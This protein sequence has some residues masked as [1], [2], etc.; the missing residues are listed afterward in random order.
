MMKDKITN[1]SIILSGIIYTIIISVSV[2]YLNH[3]AYYGR[4]DIET[5]NTSQIEI[6]GFSPL[7][8]EL[9]LNRKGGE[10]SY[11]YNRF[12]K[13]LIIKADNVEDLKGT[14]IYL[15]NYQINYPLDYTSL[16]KDESEKYY[17]E[18][19]FDSY[20]YP[21]NMKLIDI[22][23]YFLNEFKLLIIIVLISWLAFLFS[24]IIIRKRKR[25]LKQ[26]QNSIKQITT[27]S[28]SPI[29]N[30]TVCLISLLLIFLLLL[31]DKNN[32]DIA[33]DNK[34]YINHKWDQFDYHTIAAN[35]TLGYG[36]YI[37]GE[38]SNTIDYKMTETNSERVDSEILYRSG[39]KTYRPP[40]YSLFAGV[41][42]SIFG[43]NPIVIKVF[44]IILLIIVVY[45]LPNLGML[46][47]KKSGYWAGIIAGPLFIA[48][49][50][51]YT[52]LV[53]PETF[54]LTIN[55]FFVFL[56]LFLRKKKTQYLYIFSGLLLGLSILIKPSLAL[57][58]P[59][60]LI[61]V[62][63]IS[64]KNKLRI[65]DFY[66][67]SLFTFSFL[68]M[69]LPYN[70][71]T[72]HI[73]QKLSLE[74]SAYLSSLKEKGIKNTNIS[75]FKHIQFYTYRIP[76][77]EDKDLDYF[78]KTV[79][80]EIDSLLYIPQK[81]Y[82]TSNNLNTPVAFLTN[83]K[84]ITIYDDWFL[85]QPNIPLIYLLGFHNEY[86]SG[87]LARY[88]DWIYNP[89]SYYNTNKLDPS[90][91][92][93]WMNFYIN[94]PKYFIKNFFYK[95]KYAHKDLWIINILIVF[96]TLNIVLLKKWKNSYKIAFILSIIGALFFNL[97]FI[98]YPIV[99]SFFMFSKK[100]SLKIPYI[101]ILL[102]LAFWSFSFFGYGD[103]RIASYYIFP[104]FIL[105]GLYLINATNNIINRINTNKN[106]IILK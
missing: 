48:A 21:L 2:F 73:Y 89:E 38:I 76:K 49:F 71:Y 45:F 32:N 50:Y 60:I 13:T 75:D 23:I 103:E 7:G 99:L 36:F 63:L 77:I 82:R 10:Y 98:I 88:N 94:K 18:F 65:V 104:L 83:L 39:Y 40:G 12:Y 78:L 16:R 26:G 41:V 86:V 95:N 11:P 20:T 85:M 66:K 92:K 57:I 64:C 9:E 5:G 106:D 58:L 46:I 15:E 100:N 87:N 101:F 29:Q 44:N 54:T 28:P 4:I 31:K 96:A 19:G 97:F 24:F 90:P 59:L 79:E 34:V 74:S 8:S 68:I 47:W 55:F 33:F 43:I 17:L 22:I 72:N 84:L 52:L 91:V 81:Y 30:I 35:F 93:N 69:W 51:K 37:N 105:S 6:I 14:I 53:E 61:D 25:I 62:Y 27:A 1:I 42:Y 67:P 102:I 3:S 70:I 80:P 56:Y